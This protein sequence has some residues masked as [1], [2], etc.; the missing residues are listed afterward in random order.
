VKIYSSATGLEITASRISGTLANQRLGAAIAVVPDQNSDGKAD[1]VVGEPLA[2]VV[3]E[4]NGKPVTLKKAGKV[5]LYSGANGSFI[6]TVAEGK[7]AGD[8][9]GSAVSVGNA[10]NSGSIDL[11][12]G[13][14]MAEVTTEANSKNIVLTNAGQV[15]AFDGISDIEIYSRNGSQANA[16]F[17]SAIAMDADG[18]LLVGEPLYDVLTNVNSKNVVLANAGRVQMFAGD[19]AVS[20]ALGLPLDGAASNDRLGS[21]LSA[22]QTDFNNDGFAD[23]LVGVPRAN[24]TTYRATPLVKADAGRVMLMSGQNKTAVHTFSGSMKTDQLG[25]AVCSGHFNDDGATDIADFALAS[26]Q[27]DVPTTVG[28]KLVKLSNAGRAALYS[29][30]ALL[31]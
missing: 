15:T 5:S 11:L 3:T 14:P 10:N 9:F 19:E 25:T 12:V 20:P 24:I 31:P 21:S 2:N 28:T 6:K 1:I 13:A 16:R 30:A 27:F 26:P 8:G 7:K 18:N 23:W 4:A 22:T 29:G 17:G